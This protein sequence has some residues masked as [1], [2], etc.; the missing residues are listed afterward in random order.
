MDRV[1]PF[2]VYALFIWYWSHST[3]VLFLPQSLLKL[4]CASRTPLFS[5]VVRGLHFATEMQLLSGVICSPESAGRVTLSP[6]VFR[7]RLPSTRLWKYLFASCVYLE[8][9]EQID[10]ARPTE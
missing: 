6:R 3:A 5:Q 2:F 10:W 7:L 8:V 4:A 9:T 1:K